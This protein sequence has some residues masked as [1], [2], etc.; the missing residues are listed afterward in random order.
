MKHLHTVT[1][2]APTKA[3]GFAIGTKLEDLFNELLIALGLKEEEVPV[4]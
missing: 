2:L 3:A 4:A 1:K